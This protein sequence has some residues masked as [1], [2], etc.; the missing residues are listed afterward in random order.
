MTS[1][2]SVQPAVNTRRLTILGVL[3]LLL[4]PVVAAY[5]D[6]RRRSG[7]PTEDIAIIEMHTF[8]VPMH[9]PLYGVFSRFG[10]HHP[11]PLLY[12]VAALPLRLFGP[13]GL[14]VA[15]A[16]VNVLAFGGL[17]V[18][19]YRRG[20]QVLCFIGAVFALLLARA[21]GG[22]LISIW[23]AWMPVIP[24][25]LAIALTWSVWC[26]DWWA[27]PWLAGVLTWVVQNHVGY[28][29]V[30]AVLFGSSLGWAL[31]QANWRDRIRLRGAPVRIDVAAA[32]GVAVDD[33]P[34]ASESPSA[35]S[36]PESPSAPGAL[37]RC[38]GLVLGVTAAVLFVLWLP[39]LIEQFTGHPGNISEI[40]DFART[41]RD[42]L[43]GM[44]TALGVVAREVGLTSPLFGFSQPTHPI[45]NQVQGASVV[46]LLLAFVPF[47]V[48]GVIAFRA[49]AYDALR[50]QAIVALTIP[51]G[52]LAVSRIAGAVF[53]YLVT[54]LWV[55]AGFLWISALWSVLS[56]VWP[57]IGSV[58]VVPDTR[59]LD[60][61]GK[62]ALVGI[63]LL[64]GLTVWAT[65]AA[66]NGRNNL[67]QEGRV[68]EQ[69]LPTAEKAIDGK[70]RILIST[71]GKGFGVSAI[72]FGLQA[73]L[74][75]LGYDVVAPDFRAFPVGDRRAVQGRP[76][77][78]RLVIADEAG[79]LKRIDGGGNPLSTFDSLTPSERKELKALRDKAKTNGDQMS[80]VD[81]DRLTELGNRS[82]R[83]GLFFEL[84][85]GSGASTDTNPAGTSGGP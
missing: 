49:R 71:E 80:T 56:A 65:T 64:L 75:R 81:R 48:A 43:V 76:I 70:G 33:S 17:L 63:A 66:A 32:V 78:G 8:D 40:V 34:D 51:M 58:S 10:F 5:L 77:D 12:Y 13:D 74:E 3:G 67:D 60:R 44:R 21:V 7:L 16:I 24:F 38:R 9:L 45:T 85:A 1:P 31:F 57:K 62:V 35:P 23:N 50:L 11:G 61:S 59:S 73:E 79:L 55:V 46:L 36:A 83:Y 54:W 39:P 47:L 6:A 4:I 2:Q 72:A 26:R 29:P 28:A 30:A 42:D 68:T 41:H 20:G 22:D 27:L 19:M 37:A 84:G 82:D 69:F 52:L 25:A 14:M 53:P 18:V 15:A